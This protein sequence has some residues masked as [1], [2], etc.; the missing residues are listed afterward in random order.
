MQ[1]VPF[2]VYP[3]R[4]EQVKPPLVFMHIPPVA[5]LAQFEVPSV[6]SSISVLGAASALPQSDYGY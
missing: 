1:C 4:H 6:H 3:I 2:P 5:L